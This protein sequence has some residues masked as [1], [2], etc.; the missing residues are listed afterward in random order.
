MAA[1][2]R[3]GAATCD[4]TPWDRIPGAYLAGFEPNRRATAV[5]D[6]LE[7]GAV[8]LTDGRTRVCLV[9]L[10]LIGFQHPYVLRVRDRLAGRFPQPENVLIT[11]THNHQGPDTM[12]L[13]GRALLNRL[14]ILSGMDMKYQEQLVDRIADLVVEAAARAVPASMRTTRFDVPTDWLRN[15]R[16]GGAVDDFGMALAFDASDGTRIATL[17]NLAGHPESLWEGNTL[18]SADYPGSLRSRLRELGPGVPVFF[19]GSLGGM[20][21]PNIPIDAGLDERKG[22]VQRLGSGVADR[23]TEALANAPIQVDPWLLARKMPVELPL[24]NRM[25]QVLRILGISDREFLFNKVRT[26]VNLVR[27]GEDT[28]LLTVPGEA[29][30]EVGREL[31]RRIPG[32]FRM[33]LGLGCDELGYIL[34]PEQYAD[35]EWKYEKSMSVGPR[36]APMLWRAAES[37]AGE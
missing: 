32:Q 23:A 9:S 21:T 11:A 3:C 13:W 28:S 35:R 27:I 4:I 22:W 1:R 12:G 24:A 8:F 17:V 37:L 34:T 33:L 10:D 19:Q 6:P 20:V 5:L 16:S 15:D 36:T 29:T 18:V 30:P 7:A 31:A 14:P 25:F 2:F 26:E